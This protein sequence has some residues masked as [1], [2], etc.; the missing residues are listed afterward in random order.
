MLD[1]AQAV[2]WARMFTGYS[3]TESLVSAARDTFDPA[4]PCNLCLAVKAAREATRNQC[5][6][7]TAPAVEK[8]VLIIPDTGYFVGQSELK[9][10]PDRA[11]P[12]VPSRGDDVP[13]PPPKL[14][15]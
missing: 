12:P 3:G 6:S 2:A 8:V 9:E 13:L 7:D 4:K 11:L 1:V 14:A 10:W 15:A 5:P